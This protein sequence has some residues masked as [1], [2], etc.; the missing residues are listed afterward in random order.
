MPTPVTAAVCR[1][2]HGLLALEPLTL[3][4]PRA[5]EVLVRIVASGI[6][7]TDLAVR[8]QQLPT[9]L[10][11]VL[12]HEG[13]G[14]VVATGPG[15]THVAPGDRVLMSF[16]SC[17]HCPSCAADAPTYCYDFF[18]HNF[19]GARPDGQATLHSAA[20]EVVHGF[21]FGQSSFA[22]HAVASARNVVRVP[23][24]A[25]H[26]PLATLAP[27]GCGLMTGAGA[28]LR[29][30]AVAA[31]RPFVVFGAGAV[32]LAAVMAAKIV[33]ADPIVAVDLHP[34]RRA[35]A[36]ELGAT[37]ALDGAADPFACLAALCPRGVPA[38]FDTTGLAAIIEGL[39]AL[40]APKG[41]LAMVG[42][43]APDA[44]LQFNETAFMG[45]GKR[46]IGVLGGDS[47]IQGFLPDLIRHH[48]AGRF[49]FD[50]LI[51]T[52]PFA[53]INAAIADSESGE[54]VKP[55]LVIDPVVEGAL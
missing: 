5:G 53:D 43:S 11:V 15:V 3:D 41:T 54:V 26:L 16:N 10:P 52:Y 48:L 55:V 49:P 25:A 44:M 32:G 1:Q 45:G 37:H 17:G 24:E 6:C 2:P 23:D 42:A 40:L 31:G 19:S 18:A 8:D 7:H 14:I 4:D 9:P 39:F 22:T 13:A 47:D 28:V 35:L 51:R 20:G 27:L 34:G 21:F 36:L 29:S 30:M 33:G 50:R 12:G 46:V 38:A